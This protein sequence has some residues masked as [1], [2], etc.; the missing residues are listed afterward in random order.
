MTSHDRRTMARLLAD[1][2]QTFEDYLRAATTRLLT[3][4]GDGATADV[5]V[6]DAAVA[7]ARRAWAIQRAELPDVIQRAQG[8]AR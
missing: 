2:D 4:G 3:F 6:I 7:E 1:A 5:D 8:A